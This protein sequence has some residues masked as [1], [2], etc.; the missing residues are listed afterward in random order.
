MVNMISAQDARKQKEELNSV[1]ER[2]Q[3]EN[4]EAAIKRDIKKGYIYYYEQLQ[5]TVSAELK[6]LGYKV[7]YECTQRDGSITTIRW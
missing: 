4:I 2:Q 5:N 1:E 3:L 7:E 6:R